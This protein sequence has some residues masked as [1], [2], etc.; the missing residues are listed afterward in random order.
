MLLATC[1]ES[2][3]QNR[4]GQTPEMHGNH[5]RIIADVKNVAEASP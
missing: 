5:W 2:G 3:Q 1:C 4:S